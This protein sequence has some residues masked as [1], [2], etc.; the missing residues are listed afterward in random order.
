MLAANGREAPAARPLPRTECSM[1]VAAEEDSGVS[2]GSACAVGAATA[3]ATEADAC[4]ADACAAA[5]AALVGLSGAAAPVVGSAGE[6]ALTRGSALVLGAQAGADDAEVG[7]ALKLPSLEAGARWSGERA[8]SNSACRAEK[9]RCLLLSWEPP[10]KAEGRSSCATEGEDMWWWC[11]GS[12]LQRATT[13][14]AQ[15]Q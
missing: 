7:P 6:S 2:G 12:V 11:A 14:V 1:G 3:L 9:L 13:T 15:K 5:R 4:A 8:A 10:W